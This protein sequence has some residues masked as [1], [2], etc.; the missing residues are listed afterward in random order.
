MERRNSVLPPLDTVRVR[1]PFWTRVISLVKDSVLPYQWEALNDRIPGAEKSH[2]M[3]NF[4]IAAGL[5]QGDFY[6]CVF[7]DS[8]FGKWLEAAAYILHTYDDPEL[9][10]ICDDAID[11]V[12]AAQQ[13]DGYLNTYFTIKEP[14]HRWKNLKDCH[15]LY[16]AGHLMEGAVA[17]YE[18][19]GKRK[20][21]DVMCRYADYIESVFGIGQGKLP[22]YPGH[23]EIELALVKLYRVTREQRYLK[24]AAFFINQRGQTPYYFDAEYSQRHAEGISDHWPWNPEKPDR[25]RYYQCHQPVREQKDITGH[26]VRAMYLLTGMAEVAREM[27]DFSLKQAC[28]TLFDSTVLRN[29][30]ITGSIGSQV[31]G[32]AFSFD[33]DLPNDLIYGETCAAIG[34]V[35]AARSMLTIEKD[36]RYSDVMERALYNGVLSGMSLDGKAF[37]YAN[38]LEVWPEQIEKKPFLFDHVRFPRQ[39]WFGCACCPPNLARIA[40]SLGKYVYDEENGKLWLHL[41]VGGEISSAGT[42]LRIE[43]GLPWNG[44][45][46]I[47]VEKNGQ[48]ATLALRIP[49]W[50]CNARIHKNNTEIF[51]E[52]S[53]GY[54]ML[55]HCCSGDIFDLDFA[56]DPVFVYANTAVRENIGKVAI[57]MG[58]I[59]YCAEEADNGKDLHLFRADKSKQLSV[60]YVPELLGGVNCITVRGERHKP[61]GNTLYTEN[62]PEYVPTKIRLVP[63]YAWAN[64]GPGE[65]MTWMRC[66]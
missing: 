24:L 10:R 61:S 45:V 42:T 59:V 66:K 64:R 52:I 46:R 30:Y 38:P 17:Y 20:F 8:D 56:M 53:D 21:L 6:G 19:T 50:A 32:E 9:E 65:L 47:F 60:E 2:C 44:K 34:L 41:Y 26:S 1:D 58:P 28:R 18:A 43:S 57:Q 37:F 62:S 48:N 36:S 51:P 31:Q 4:R 7:Q 33:Y 49:G 15:E 25:Y 5:K 12:S 16:C 63:Y 14:E 29:M 39:R 35:F 40:A 22:G 27:G 55:P 11:I 54:A 13:Q 23:E 3:E